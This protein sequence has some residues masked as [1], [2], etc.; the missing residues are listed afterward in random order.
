MKLSHSL[1]E[2]ERGDGLPGVWLLREHSFEEVL[3]PYF[4]G[5]RNDCVPAVEQVE[6]DGDNVACSTRR[7]FTVETSDGLTERS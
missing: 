2:L 4:L 6:L 7:E 1:L 3:G 5:L